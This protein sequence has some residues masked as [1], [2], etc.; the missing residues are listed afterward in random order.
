MPEIVTV[1]PRIVPGAPPPTPLTKSQKKKRRAKAKPGAENSTDAND[2]DNVDSPA[3][4]VPDAFA[5]ALVEASPSVGDVQ[6]CTLAPEPVAPPEAETPTILDELKLSPIVELVNKKLKITTKKITRIS[7][8]A[9]TDSDQLNDDQKR[10]LKTLPTLEAIQKELADVKKAVETYEAGL[11]HELIAKKLEAEKAERARIAEA[12]AV[13]Q[14]TSIQKAVEILDLLRLRSLLASGKL[15]TPPIE[16]AE[17]SAILAIADTLLNTDDEKR[18]TVIKDYLQGSGDFDGIPH[19]RIV[20]IT[21][22][23]LAPPRIPTPPPAE[24]V[25]ETEQIEAVVESPSVPD[26]AVISVPGPASTTKGFSFVQESEIDEAQPEDDGE[27]TDVVGHEQSPREEISN[28]H[29]QQAVPVVDQ[30]QEPVTSAIEEPT[31]SAPLDWAT[32]E[33]DLPPISSIQESFG[34][35]GAAI[36]VDEQAESAPDTVTSPTNGQMNGPRPRRQPQDEEGFT[37]GR[38]RGRGYRGERGGYRGFRGER[39]AF[40][41]GDRGGFRGRGGE[42]RGGYRGRGEWRGNGEY[43]GRGRGRGRGGPGGERGGGPAMAQPSAP[44]P[45]AT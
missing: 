35:S 4:T 23:G 24:Q 31:T 1:Q 12:V 44:A 21:D 17:A 32:E 38:G 43:R 45:V 19:T 16:Q 36:P 5:A 39:G 42:G 20:E 28:E 25:A 33:G 6:K 11:V 26:V 27:W 3:T 8:Y 34:T 9:A 29:G 30:V 2:I 37:R 15:N 41:G 13:A 40:R 10:T 14:E 18:N 22:A 7:I